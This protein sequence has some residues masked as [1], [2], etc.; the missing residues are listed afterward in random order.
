NVKTA[1]TNTP[2]SSPM[3]LTATASGDAVNGSFNVTVSQLA[4]ATR[5]L[6]S[7]PLGQVIDKSVALVNAGFRLE[8]IVLTNGNP[9][10]FTINGQT[11]SVDAATTLDD[12]SPNS[13]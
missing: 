13:I 6:S 1:S 8:P 7:G 4:T 11:I 3:V 9:A 12:G 5:V 2:S 10:G